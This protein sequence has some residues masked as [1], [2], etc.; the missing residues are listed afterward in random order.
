MSNALVDE[1]AI[2]RGIEIAVG[3]DA[4]VFASVNDGFYF[5]EVNFKKCRVEHKFN[6]KIASFELS[7]ISENINRVVIGGFL[8]SLN[9]T[10]G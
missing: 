6:Y 7:A 8:D 5:F 2:K 3:G 4:Q 9:K 1:D 10:K